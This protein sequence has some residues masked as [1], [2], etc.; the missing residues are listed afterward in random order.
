METINNI[1]ISIGGWDPCGGAGL[2]ADIK[3]F[4]MLGITGMGVCSA[5]T[6]QTENEFISVN[7]IDNQ[8]I[9]DQLNTLLNKYK[10]KAIK[11]GIIKNLELLLNI[12]KKTSHIPVIWDPVLKASAG[13]EFHN[14]IDKKLL[15][16]ILKQ[17]Y[18][19]TPNC[20]EASVLF[21]NEKSV[22][23]LHKKIITNNISNILLKG[24]HANNHA[25]DT[26]ITKKGIEIFKGERFNNIGKH[27]SGC[28]LSSAIAS[29][30]AS[31]LSI[32]DS[33]QQAKKYVEEFIQST[34]EL[35]GFHYRK[36][37]ISN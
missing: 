1:V 29:K 16:S 15:I 36:S 4:E 12:L 21:K 9:L 20:Y 2:A 28:V 14:K 23:E 18:L 37:I 30:V 31:G 13:Y 6:V 22:K 5:I 3:T 19:I 25:D 33:C 7:W 11:I 8:L 17:L 26:L 24:G 35:L 34:N 32:T 27:G 10:P